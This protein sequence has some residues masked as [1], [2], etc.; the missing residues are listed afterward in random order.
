M[1]PRAC[2]P[3]PISEGCDLSTVA[4]YGAFCV[5]GGLIATR[6]VIAFEVYSPASSDRPKATRLLLIARGRIPAPLMPFIPRG[7]REFNSRPA[8]R[9]NLG[10]IFAAMTAQGAKAALTSLPGC[11]GALFVQGKPN[12]P[13]LLRIRR[14][15]RRGR[16]LARV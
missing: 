6:S 13:S 4:E 7:V 11:G 15:N 16:R 9:K 10:D 2:R 12:D 8:D 14:L 3:L 5:A 1:I